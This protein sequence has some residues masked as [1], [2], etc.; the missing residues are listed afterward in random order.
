[1]TQKEQDAEIGQVVRE[2]AEAR[3][4]VT[5][6]ENKAETTANTL[7]AIA[8]ELTRKEK[9][10]TVTKTEHGF[11]ITDPVTGRRELQIPSAKEIADLIEDLHKTIEKIRTLKKKRTE[12]GID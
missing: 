12:F 6:L 2:H 4:H 11:T 1:M 7:L 5:C 10:G 8:N 3:R 9:R